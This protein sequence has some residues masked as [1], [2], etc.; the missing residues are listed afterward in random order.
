MPDVPT[1]GGAKRLSTM[2][3]YRGACGDQAI[4]PARMRHRSPRLLAAVVACVLLAGAALGEDLARVT[5]VADGDT[6]AVRQGDRTITIRLIG[7]D[8]PELGDRRRPD[9]PPQAFAREATDWLRRQLD[10]R[11]VRLEYD[12]ERT[13][14]YGRT[15]AYVFL[16]DGTFINRELVRQGY[17]RAYTRFPFKFREQFVADEAAAQRAKR[18]MWATL[19][20][21]PVIGNRRSRVYHLPGQNHYDDV[22]PRNRVYFDSEDAAR[23]AGYHPSR[24]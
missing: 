7:V 1:N 18:G 23:A 10:G 9:A 12:R 3:S 24:R 15:L 21:G 8:A 6:I 17:A 2:R 4:E 19:A 11:E 14:R 5:R 16:P 13:D 20:T 22:A